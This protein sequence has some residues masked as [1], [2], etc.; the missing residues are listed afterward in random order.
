[1]LQIE[2]QSYKH[3]KINKWAFRALLWDFTAAETQYKKYGNY[4]GIVALL[5]NLYFEM[6]IQQTQ[7]ELIVLLVYYILF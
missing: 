7:N 2:R 5:Q 1:M 4:F 6:I 3:L